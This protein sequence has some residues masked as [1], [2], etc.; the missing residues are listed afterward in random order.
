[1]DQENLS[2]IVLMYKLMNPW[3]FITKKLDGAKITLFKWRFA[4]TGG[5]Q[6]EKAYVHEGGV[7]EIED[8]EP[9]KECFSEHFYE[10]LEEETG[11][12][13]LQNQNMHVVF[14]IL[15]RALDEYFERSNKI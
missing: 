11:A 3:N 15:L 10:I 14:V 4:W 12:G 9:K 7:K 2:S 8:D 6:V 1:M 13:S 5:K